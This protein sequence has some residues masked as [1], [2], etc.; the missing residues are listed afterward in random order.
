MR[1]KHAIWIAGVAIAGAALSAGVS[2]GAEPAIEEPVPVPPIAV[3]PAG[4]EPIQAPPSGVPENGVQ[5]ATTSPETWLKQVI[6]RIKEGRETV[7]EAWR[8]SEL[9]EDLTLAALSSWELVD[10]GIAMQSG[11]MK[12]ARAL[13]SELIRRRPEMLKDVSKF[14]E[15]SVIHL[16]N[17]LMSRGDARCVAL[18]EN[19]L[20]R[21]TKIVPYWD[22]S[23]DASIYNLAGYYERK[24]QLEKALKTKQRIYNYTTFPGLLTNYD[25]QIGRL[26]QKMGRADEAKKAFARP[27]QRGDVRDIAM[28]R[29]EKSDRLFREGKTAEARA[30]LLLPLPGP[31]HSAFEIVMLTRLGQSYLD[32]GD[33]ENAQK[34]ITQAVSQWK[35][36]PTPPTDSYLVHYASRAEAMS[37]RIETRLKSPFFWEKENVQLL[38]W[39]NGQEQAQRLILLFKT[40]PTGAVEFECDN[41]AVQIEPVIATSP[42]QNAL[43]RVVY[44]RLASS[45]LKDDLKKDFSTV[46]IARSPDFPGQEARLTVNV[47]ILR[48]SSRVPRRTI[49]PKSVYSKY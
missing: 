49:P 15:R 36:M 37:A 40:A 31:P 18:Y 42:G 10:A 7:P 24:G 12:L 20:K 4:T 17:Y 6:G 8:K 23:V 45:D 38:S 27:E 41:P 43:K 33:L 13:A 11:D 34:Y 35:G 16:A 48:M 14:S 22:D 47:T 9:D 3:A 19:V 30:M 28:T 25:Y 26:Y 39:P 2:L 29:M 5:S 1:R 32:E 44:I 46:V 21:K